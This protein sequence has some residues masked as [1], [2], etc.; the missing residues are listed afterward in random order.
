M[1]TIIGTLLIWNWSLQ[2]NTQEIDPTKPD[3]IAV[4]DGSGAQVSVINPVRLIDKGSLPFGADVLVSRFKVARVCCT[5]YK[6]YRCIAEQTQHQ[7]QWN[8]NEFAPPT[9]TAKMW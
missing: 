7:Y 9:Y 3:E 1:F 6:V 2:E 5:K 8:T 4:E